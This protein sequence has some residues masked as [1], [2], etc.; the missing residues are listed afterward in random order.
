MVTA[1]EL[2][3]HPRWVRGIAHDSVEV[4]HPIELAAGPNELVEGGA[5]R[6]DSR[7]II[8][9]ALERQNSGPVDL[10]AGL[11][12]PANDLLVASDDL[13][14]AHV[15]QRNIR[16]ENARRELGESHVV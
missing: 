13:R 6:L 3:P 4:D 14:R 8:T 15:G 2:R 10:R 5:L 9:G 11:M 16:P 12:H 1:V 7:V